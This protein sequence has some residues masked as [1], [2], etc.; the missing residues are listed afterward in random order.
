MV[1]FTNY[2]HLVTK[3]FLSTHKMYMVFCGTLATIKHYNY[4]SGTMALD[5]YKLNI[6]INDIAPFKLFSPHLV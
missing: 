3:L 2:F 5:F 1:C 6:P 4:I